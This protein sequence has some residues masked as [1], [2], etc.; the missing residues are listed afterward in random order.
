VS[1]APD[2]RCPRRAPAASGVEVDGR[3]ALLDRS[4][5]SLHVLN[6]VGAAI[7]SRL[8]G[9]YT[10]SSLVAEL[11]E[12][13]GAEPARV[14]D[15][16]QGFL[17]RLGRLGLLEG[18]TAT[19]DVEPLRTSPDRDS[20]KIDSAWVDWYTGQVVDA[21][22]AQGIESIVLKGPAIRGWL[23]RDAPGE[24][25]YVDADLL[26]AERNMSAAAAVLSELGFRHEDSR[27]ME[28]IALWA[29]SWRRDADGAVVDLHRTLH[30]CEH[31]PVD[32]WPILRAT[33]VEE[34]IGGSCVALVSIPARALQI[35][36]VSPDDRPWHKWNDLERALEQLPIEGWRDA[37]AVAD[38]LGVERLFGYRLSQS[39]AGAR[40]AQHLGLRT[41]PRWWLRWDAD[42]MLRWIVLLAA[43][44]SWGERVRLA[45]ALIMPP[46]RYVRSRDPEAARGGVALAYGAWAAHVLRLVPGAITTLLRSLLRRR[47]RR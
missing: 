35:V 5:G 36:L 4:T 19:G 13:F 23:Y 28:R 16:V 7:W 20:W 25:G 26:V 22:R 45:R 8:D 2:L 40:C 17:S 24:R 43:V 33:A 9:S 44:P 32:P 39:P 29:T 34:E 38:A 31:S 11:S 21:L 10:V 30:G 41:A 47:V 6:D 42:P 27:G 15:D 1:W 12:E 14:V 3:L 46:V 37:A 18:S